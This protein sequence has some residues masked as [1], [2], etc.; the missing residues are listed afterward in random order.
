MLAVAFV[1][2]RTEAPAPAAPD[3][4]A[5]HASLSTKRPMVTLPWAVPGSEYEA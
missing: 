2:V 4:V 3:G 1:V 5:A